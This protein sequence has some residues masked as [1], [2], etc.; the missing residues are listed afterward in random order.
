MRSSEILG[1]WLVYE[2]VVRKH[3]IRKLEL[4][5][6][7]DPKLSYAKFFSERKIDDIFRHYICENLIQNRTR[8]QIF[9]IY[10]FISSS[11]VKI[12]HVDQ[13]SSHYLFQN[14]ELQIEVPNTRIYSNHKKRVVLVM[15]FYSIRRDL[16]FRSAI[17]F[18]KTSIGKD[19]HLSSMFRFN[20]RRLRC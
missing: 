14:K 6:V 1:W 18:W 17:T 12:I 15:N 16:I 13:T 10:Y 2:R 11:S 7:I 4:V 20:L 9:V 19:T 5:T 8:K 3:V